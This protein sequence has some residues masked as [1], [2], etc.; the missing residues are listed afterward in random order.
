MTD[1][2][3]SGLIATSGRRKPVVF[4]WILERALGSLIRRG[5]LHLHLPDGVTRHFGKGAPEISVT[6]H[7]WQTLRRIALNADRR[8]A[9]G[10]ER[11]YLRPA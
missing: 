5:T 2:G 11:R 6:I 7:D 1:L 9:D 3:N 10:R 8:H 4:L